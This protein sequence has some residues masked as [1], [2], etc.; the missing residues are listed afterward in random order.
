MG[1]VFLKCISVFNRK[2]LYKKKIKYTDFCMGISRSGHLDKN[3]LLSIFKR[4]PEGTT[5]IVCHPGFS[6][7]SM[8]FYNHWHYNWQDELAAL[9]S[10]TIKKYIS[11]HKI[12]IINF[13]DLS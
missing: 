5:E 3:A 2:Q 6:D 4:I 8:T 10:P 13:K 12:E 1:L 9:V 11:D 7:E